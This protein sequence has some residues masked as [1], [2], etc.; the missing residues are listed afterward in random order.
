MPSLSISEVDLKKVSIIIIQSSF[1]L[2]GR[3]CTHCVDIMFSTT[4]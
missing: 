2:V 3:D 4:A 1:L